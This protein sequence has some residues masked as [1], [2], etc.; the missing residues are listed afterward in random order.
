MIKRICLLILL[1]VSFWCPMGQA[2]EAK[3]EK[4]AFTG[5]IFAFEINLVELREACKGL[6]QTFE[7]IWLLSGNHIGTLFISPESSLIEIDGFG[8]HDANDIP[9]F[10]E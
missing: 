3:T 1:M 10:E 6:E 9:D 5:S 8:E 7:S 4:D 2:K